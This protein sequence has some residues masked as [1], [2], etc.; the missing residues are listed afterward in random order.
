MT[1]NTKKMAQRRAETYEV[2][3]ITID[4]P[5]LPVVL[6]EVIPE[7]EVMTKGKRRRFTAQHKLDIL[8]QADAC[9]K[10]GSLGSLLRREGLYSSHLTTWRHQMD[11]GKLAALTPKKRGRK[12]L[13]KNPLLEENVRLNKANELLTRRLKQAETIIDVQKKI[14][15]LLNLSQETIVKGEIE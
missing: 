2:D 3:T 8:K 10:K 6:T 12:E 14:S 11:R 5:A 9:S 1:A 13:V 7:P 4:Q 15:M